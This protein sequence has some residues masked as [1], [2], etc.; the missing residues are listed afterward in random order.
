LINKYE[1]DLTP[2]EFESKMQT[3]EKEKKFFY[4]VIETIFLRQEQ[5]VKTKN[6]KKKSDEDMND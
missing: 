2:E 6:R 4:L 1:K 3:L 5:D